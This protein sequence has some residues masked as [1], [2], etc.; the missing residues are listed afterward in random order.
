MTRKGYPAW[1]VSV[2]LPNFPSDG[3]ES[4]LR[5]YAEL[6][7]SRKQVEEG[8]NFLLALLRGAGGRSGQHVWVRRVAMEGVAALLS[9]TGQ[10]AVNLPS[11]HFLCNE[12]RPCCVCS[13]AP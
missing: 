1:S 6:Q 11:Y 4:S 7:W 12:S 3:T 5:W 8:A 9:D 2:S 13:H 10:K